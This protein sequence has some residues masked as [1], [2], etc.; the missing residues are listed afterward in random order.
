MDVYYQ[1][2]LNHY[3]TK[4]VFD[5][6]NQMAGVDVVFTHK[7]TKN[8]FYIDEKAQL[9]YINDDLPTFAFELAYNKNGT[10]KEGWLFDI[11]KKTDFYALATAIYEDEPSVFTTCKITLVNRKK[12]CTFLEH[13]NVTKSSLEKYS[14]KTT[15]KHGKLKLNELHHR[16]EGY[17][18]FSRNNK[19]EK[20]INLILKLDFLVGQ[21]IAKRLV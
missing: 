10:Y 7:Q 1:N 21:G 2:H 13:R 19:V 18:Y 17:L 4:R 6:K 3:N 14:K 8:R 20:P 11:N 12:L 15:E 16:T 9:D 5:M